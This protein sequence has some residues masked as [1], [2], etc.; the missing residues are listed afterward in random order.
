LAKILPPEAPAP[1]RRAPR[2]GALQ[3]API[4]PDR[5]A[6]TLLAPEVRAA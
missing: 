6:S 5:A 2:R 1:R 4:L 3:P